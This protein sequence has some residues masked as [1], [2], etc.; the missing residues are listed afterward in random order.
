MDFGLALLS[1]ASR[2]TRMDETVGTTA[3]MSPEQTQGSGADHRTDLW[4]LGVV[5]YETITGRQ[6]FKG[7]YDKAVMYSIVNEAPEP[8]TALRTGVPMGLERIVDKC[9]AKR[10]EDRYQSAVELAVDLRAIDSNLPGRT[11]TKPLAGGTQRSSA[12]SWKLA[13]PLIAVAAAIAFWAFTRNVSQEAHEP[14]KVTRVTSTPELEFQVAG[15]PGSS[16]IA[17]SSTAA[18][19]MDIYVMPAGG[20]KSLQLTDLAG[21]EWEP[22]LSPDGQQVVFF[23][24]TEGGDLYSV[25]V[26]GGTPRPLAHTNFGAIGGVLGANPWRVESGRQQLL[27]TRRDETDRDAIW[28]ID[29]ASLEEIQL[30][31][32]QQGENHV[33]ASY[34]PS[35]DRIVFTRRG[36]GRTELWTM[37]ADGGAAR[38]LLDDEFVNAFPSWAPDG[39]RI[40]FQSNRAGSVN[41]WELNITGGGLSQIT[42]GPGEEWW[43]VVVDGAGVFYIQFGHTL[44]LFSVDIQQGAHRALT[45]G[46]NVEQTNPRFSPDGRF[47]VFDN[48]RG[49]D[50]E[51]YRLDLGSG[52]TRPLT[53]NEEA[54]RYPDWSP[55]SDELLFVSDRDGEAALWLMDTEGRGSRR[56]DLGP[57]AV[58]PHLADNTGGGPGPPRWSPTGDVIGYVGRGE[59]T[60]ELWSVHSDGSAAT[61]LLSGVHSFDWYGSSGRVVVYSTTGGKQSVGAQ[62]RAVNLDTKEEVVLLE[63]L[64]ANLDVAPDRSS[65]AYVSQDGHMSQQYFLLPLTPA[66]P[67]DGLPR[68]AGPPRPL[69]EG[70]GLWHV[71]GGSFS[72]DGSTF[73]YDRDADEGDIVLIENYE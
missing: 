59:T 40:V 60:P 49:G 55:T 47:L 71:H 43:P 5:L 14:W 63:G 2:L 7:D 26:T 16:L 34:S 54:D 52:E 67:N 31:R 42:V 33:S 72:P 20:G 28:R 38:L 46:S 19:S 32:P 73:A 22:R 68:P 6:P 58:T 18:G 17:Y 51:V 53:E 30:S 24:T 41:L 13:L 70:G 66:A 8:I 57:E 64:F 36:G 39:E 23:T 29:L 44:N 4:A 25:P 12:P 69:T 37:E 11:A 27:F 62:I 35:G 45:V 48:E 15:S 1:E 21:D 50:F 10:A 61:R 3:Y 56:L 9:L 65:V